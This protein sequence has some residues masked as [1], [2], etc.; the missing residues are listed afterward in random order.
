MKDAN[1]I[2]ADRLHARTLHCSYNYCG[3]CGRTPKSN[4]EPNYAPLRWW[5]PDDGWK[6]GTLC[7]W[8]HDEVVN[9]LPKPTDYAYSRTNQVA[10][11]VNTDTDPIDAL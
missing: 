4:D 5:D 7:H 3:I 10:D 2:R 9:D 8:C 1:Q 11:D 6:I